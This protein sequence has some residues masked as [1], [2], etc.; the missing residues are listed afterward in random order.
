[1]DPIGW[2]RI[3][4]GEATAVVMSVARSYQEYSYKTDFEI[5]RENQDFG[6][7]FF[8]M[9]RP[10]L[11]S[12]PIGTNTKNAMMS[13]LDLT[14]IGTKNP[15]PTSL[16]RPTELLKRKGKVHVPEEM[17]SDPSSSDS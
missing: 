17:E 3:I 2:R 5:W 7:Q 15:E 4:F 1:M 16:T 11:K 6:S 14:P 13:Q 9:S 10:P 8:L 12:T